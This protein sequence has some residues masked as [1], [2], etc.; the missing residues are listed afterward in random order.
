MRTYTHIHTQP[1]EGFKMQGIRHNKIEGIMNQ[2]INDQDIVHVHNS[3]STYLHF[4]Y[5]QRFSES[6]NPA[7][8][9][10]VDDE[11]SDIIQRQKAEGRSHAKRATP[12]AID[13]DEA[14]A[15]SVHAPNPN[16]DNIVA[17]NI[18]TYEY[19]YSRDTLMKT[20]KGYNQESKIY[21]LRSQA[22]FPSGI[23]VAGQPRSGVSA[24]DRRRP[25]QTTPG[26][27]KEKANKERNTKRG[28]RSHAASE[29][30][31]K[32]RSEK[33][34]RARQQN[35]RTK[36]SLGA[37]AQEPRPYPLRL[38]TEQDTNIAS[39]NVRGI[40]K[41]GK[42][43]DI[44]NYMTNKQIPIMC[45]QET[46]NGGNA[47]EIRKQYSWYFS[48]GEE[49]GAI[50][51]GVGI[52]IS[53]KLRNYVKDIEPINERI[54]I[55]HIHG[56]IDLHIISAYAPTAAANTDDKEQFYEELRKQTKK[57]SKRGIVIIGAD[58]NC[59]LSEP[60]A[61]EGD[62]I[63]PHVFGLGQAVE[64]IEGVEENR[65]FLLEYLVN[66][67]MQLSNTMFKENDKYL[68]TYRADKSANN[69]PP[70]IRGRFEVLDYIIIP[71]RWKNSI[72]DV[73]SNI[74]SGLDTLPSNR[75][76]SM[77]A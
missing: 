37:P 71:Q 16:T 7:K 19:R 55:A 48:G 10:S 20:R 68:I 58:M 35:R 5:I 42:R 45:I 60:G 21:T 54:M 18:S 62:G 23:G 24:P 8:Q 17:Y 59:K 43:Q 56:A 50:H 27:Q 30:R 65:A 38:Q 11:T 47:R 63:G 36:R 26:D 13:T 73:Y 70:Y 76:V 52:V 72:R 49:E 41:L 2:V 22:F 77:Q 32:Q 53:N 34:N 9:V 6:H 33:R 31:K 61:A 4:T 29:R 15:L 57:Y 39:L 51:H 12:D 1:F 46:H 14:A 3:I 69:K 25:R 44:E 28:F 66:S 75:K 64:E 67:S 74:E 40:R